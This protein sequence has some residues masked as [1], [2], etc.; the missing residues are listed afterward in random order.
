SIVSN[1]PDTPLITLALRGS[2]LLSPVIGAVPSQFALTMFKKHRQ[3][4]TLTLSNTGGN[5]LDFSLN[6]KTRSTAPDPAICTP[7]AYVSE[8]SAGRM[9][10]VNLATGATSPLT[11]G[12][13]TPQENVAIDPTG[14]VAYVAESDPG[15]LAAIDLATGRVSRVVSGLEF[16]VGVALTPSGTTAF[17]SEARS[18]HGQV[19]AVDLSTGAKTAVA[20]GLGAP[21]G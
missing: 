20:T 9:S 18:G 6:L 13:R 7:M 4:Q 1:D 10:A 16:P 14:T 3:P 5:A 8:W 12:L 15:T 19:T 17:V 21:N 2:G 11:V